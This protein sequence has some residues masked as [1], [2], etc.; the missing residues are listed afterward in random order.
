MHRS[1]RET[2]QHHKMEQSSPV[3]PEVRRRFVSARTARPVPWE[4]RDCFSDNQKTVFKRVW[5]AQASRRDPVVSA[6]D[7][8]SSVA[9]YTQNH[10][11]NMSTTSYEVSA[12][13]GPRKRDRLHVNLTG[14]LSVSTGGVREHNWRVYSLVEV[15]A[16]REPWHGELH[17]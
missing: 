10:S 5:R 4:G 15:S 12:A 11:Y 13:G 1:P 14:E 17:T 7:K 2:S 3:T 9:S 6:L 16:A 8:K